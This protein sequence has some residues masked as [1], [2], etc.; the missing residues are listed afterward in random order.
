M[1][2]L[3]LCL[4]SI[5]N[6]YLF[7]FF[8][9]Y[10]NGYYDPLHLHPFDHGSYEISEP[11]SILELTSKHIFT[12]E[13]RSRAQGGSWG[14]AQDIWESPDVHAKSAD[15]I[16]SKLEVPEF[17]GDLLF[18]YVLAYLQPTLQNNGNTPLKHKVDQLKAKGIIPVQPQQ[19]LWYDVWSYTLKNSE[20]RWCE[21]KY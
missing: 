8:S 3:F 4:L 14:V 9:D 11:S 16:A 21:N 10:S 6:F 15:Y 2:L 12:L 7:I 13:I 19:H 20:G 18:K 17:T 5:K 1:L